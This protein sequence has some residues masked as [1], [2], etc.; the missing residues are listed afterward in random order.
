VADLLTAL[1]WK[2]GAGRAIC[3]L[4]VI[5]LTTLGMLALGG[6]VSEVTGMSPVVL[7]IAIW[8]LWLLWL[9]VIFPRNRARDAGNHCRYPFRRAFRR[10]ILPGIAVAFSQLLR[11]VLSGIS[12]G[13]SPPAPY[14]AIGLSLFCVGAAVVFSGVSALGVARTLFVYEYVPTD[15]PVT[16]TGIFRILRHPLFLGGS[17][18]SLGLAIGTGTKVAVALGLVNVCVIPLYVQLE[19]RR[20]CATLGRPYVDYRAV[21]GGVIPRRRSAITPSALSH[22][23]SGS[24]RPTRPRDFATTR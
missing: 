9:G 17:L 12:A 5:A 10:E 19:D 20:C 3:L 2:V 22:H 16:T 23:D 7:Q 11:P 6:L 14:T 8:A 13:A 15:E 24:I 18:A 4:A 21:V 1:D